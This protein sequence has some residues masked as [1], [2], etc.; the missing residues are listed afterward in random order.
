MNCLYN[1]TKATI[2]TQDIIE[3]PMDHLALPKIKDWAALPARDL[4]DAALV[5]QTAR[6]DELEED[7]H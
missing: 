2:L 7:D 6:N 4:E 3:E 1:M 5:D